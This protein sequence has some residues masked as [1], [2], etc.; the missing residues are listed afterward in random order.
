[1]LTIVKTHFDNQDFKK[2]VA[3]LDQ[4]LAIRDGDDHAFYNQF[5]SS[6]TLVHCLVAYLDGISVGCGAIRPFSENKI[7]VKRMFVPLEFRG[8]GIASKMLTELEIGSKALGFSSCILETGIHQ[9]EA[10]SLYKKMNY[11]IIPNYGQYEQVSTSICFE[12]KFK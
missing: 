12:K 5:N 7:E 11:K 1:M 4:E 10:I 2:L 3:S 6:S 9:P 8:K